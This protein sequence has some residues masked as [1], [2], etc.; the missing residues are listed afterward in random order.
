[1]RRLRQ[2]FIERDIGFTVILMPMNGVYMGELEKFGLRSAYDGWR[3]QMKDIFG[4]VLD[5]GESYKGFENYFADG[6]HFIP[7]IGRKILKSALE[8]VGGGGRAG[9]RGCGDGKAR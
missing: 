2:L 9:A 5:F 3:K 4:N 1:M 6:T 7:P 8:A